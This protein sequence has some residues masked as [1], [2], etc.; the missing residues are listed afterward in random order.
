MDDLVKTSMIRSL[1]WVAADTLTY[2]AIAKPEDLAG[3]VM[4]FEAQQWFNLWL[5]AEGSQTIPT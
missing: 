2:Y 3:K 5:S 4:V 1:P